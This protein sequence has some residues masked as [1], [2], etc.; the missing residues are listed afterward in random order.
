MKMKEQHKACEVKEQSRLYKIG[1]FAN[2]N[3]VTIKTLRYYDE[4]NLIKPVYV[5]KE[6]GYRYYAAG[7]IA[8]L[9]RILALRGMG[10]SIEDIRKI[11]N[12]EEEKKLLQEKKQEI[13]KEIAAL[14]AKLAEVESY[15][16]KDEVALAQPVLIK[17]LPKVEVCTMEKIIESYDSLFE[18]M[19]EMGEEMEKLGC[20]CDEPEYCFT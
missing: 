7:Q 2:M 16:Y 10:F 3:R 6:N 14:T 5:D 4:Q 15:L 12:G 8:D 1:M 13:L 20:I 19:P 9:H 11:I 18:I 17:K